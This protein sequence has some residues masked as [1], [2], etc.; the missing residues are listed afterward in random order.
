LKVK[1]D[2]N[3]PGAIAE[4]MRA[5][6][7]DVDTVLEESLG[8]RSDPDVLAAAT[9]EGR[10]LMTLDRGFGDV[11]SYPPGSHPGIVVLR[12]DPDHGQPLILKKRL[13]GLL[14]LRGERALAQLV[15]PRTPLRLLCESES[16]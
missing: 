9:A 12:P 4:L 5:R 11:R 2:E 16:R 7:F 1:L 3:I 14:G 10:M 6:E 8:G 13:H 15:A